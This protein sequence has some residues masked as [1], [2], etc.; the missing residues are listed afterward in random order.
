MYPLH[1]GKQIAKFKIRHLM[2]SVCSNSTICDFFLHSG[3]FIV[4]QLTVGWSRDSAELNLAFFHDFET[5]NVLFR[6]Q[7]F[8]IVGSLYKFLFFL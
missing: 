3:Y 2:L 8:K 1:N 5:P 7:D 6:P 4:N